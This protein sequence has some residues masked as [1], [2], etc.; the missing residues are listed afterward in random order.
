MAVSLRALLQ[1]KRQVLMTNQVVESTDITKS[2]PPTSSSD[3]SFPPKTQFETS[4]RIF[5]DLPVSSE[6]TQPKPD[7]LTEISTSS[8]SIPNSTDS[9]THQSSSILAIS[10]P[11]CSPASPTR[12]SSPLISSSPS[13]HSHSNFS[14]FID[15]DDDLFLSSEEE[16]LGITFRKR[17]RNLEPIVDTKK[18]KI[19]TIKPEG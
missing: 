18:R 10:S 17:K 13:L 8:S 3:I 1:K 15:S 11:L 14:C 4:P 5:N 19:S 2:S 16:E 9:H 6:L 7:Q 12:S